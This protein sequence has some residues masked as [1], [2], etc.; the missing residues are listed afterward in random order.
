MVIYG[1]PRQR[2]SLEELKTQLVEALSAN[3]CLDGDSLAAV[4]SCE[5][6]DLEEVQMLLEDLYPKSNYRASFVKNP[7]TVVVTRG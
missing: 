7:D 2:L 3:G 6:D 1:C 5:P 4:L